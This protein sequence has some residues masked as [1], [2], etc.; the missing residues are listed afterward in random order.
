MRHPIGL[1]SF[2]L[3]WAA[4]LAA[5]VLAQP[6]AEAPKT[7]AVRVPPTLQRIRDTGTVL[8]AHRTDAVPFAYLAPDRRPIG[9][10]ID[11]C[12]QIVDALKRELKRPDLKVA[13]VPVDARTRFTAIKEGKADLECGNTVNNPER[14]KDT[15]YSMPYFFTG[16]R[17]LTR[18]D[19][20]IKDLI[21]L[22]G[23]RLV[24]VAGTNSVPIIKKHIESNYLVGARMIEVKG[25]PE[26]FKMVEAGEADA[27]ITIEPLLYGQRAAAKEPSRYHVVGGYLILEPV[28]LLLRKEDVEFKRFV[29]R[30]IANLMLDGT[31][32]KLY[33]K[34]FQS[35]IP[36]DNVTLDM[37]MSSVLRDQLRW[38]IDRTGDEN[39]DR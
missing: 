16:P 32:A 37:P 19:S 22:R 25:Y 15:G 20:G 39:P 27:F 28:A 12:L 29:D 9:F 17:I 34:W 2:L 18:V 24:V 1:P 10:G 7:E 26:A 31:Y 23:K 30:Q 38:P 33:K 11:F 35:P 5:P 14:R 4:A 36:P 8:I 21:D 3:A 6:K 13:W